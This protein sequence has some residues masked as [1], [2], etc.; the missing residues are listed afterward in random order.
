MN[1][2]NEQ[3]SPSWSLK[4]DCVER[5]AYNYNVFTPEECDNIIQYGKTKQLYDG[6]IGFHDEIQVNTN[7]RDSKIVFLHPCQETN[8]IYRKLTDVVVSLNNQ[9]FN[10]DLWGFSENIQFAEYQAPGG[11]YDAHVDRSY[12]N[13]IRKL[14]IVVQLT[15]ESEYDGGDFEI[16]DSD[17]NNPTKLMRNRGCI[18]AFPSWQLHRVTPVIRGTRHSLVSWISGP[19]FK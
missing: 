4:V 14:S 11:K 12:H 2:Q 5:Y 16:I 9:Y 17:I 10:F 18:L 6:K 3:P 15:D 19:Q 8:W 7:I 13:M 1:L